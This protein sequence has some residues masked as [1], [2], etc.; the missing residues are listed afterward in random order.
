MNRVLITGGNG[1]LG[2]NLVRFFLRKSYVVCVVSRKCNNLADVMD[3]IEFIEHTSPGYTQFADQIKAFN[4]T[5]VIHCAWDGGNSYADINSPRQVHNISDGVE[6]IDLLRVVEPAPRF[7]GLG[8]FAEYGSLASR[9]VETMPDNPTTLYGHTKVCFKTVSK[10][11]CEQNGLQ[12]I[13]IRPC[14]IYGPGDVSTRFIPSMLRRL[15]VDEQLVVDS[16]ASTVDYLHVYDFCAGVGCI[17]D[18]GSVGVFNVCSGEEYSIRSV[19]DRMIEVVGRTPTIVVDRSLDR[20]GG[21]TYTCGQPEKILSLGW[22]PK[23]DISRGLR[24]TYSLSAENTG[25]CFPE[26]P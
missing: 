26:W 6:L 9:A 17:L 2:S 3:S 14:Y 1:F 18:T 10:R 4:P 5:D 25:C 11:L 7:V 21:P 22:R 8:S 12:W 13:W 20:T 19:L 23:L 24:L 16:C 15:R